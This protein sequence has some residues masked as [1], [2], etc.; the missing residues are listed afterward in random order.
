MQGYKQV[1]LG[2]KKTI[3]NC[4]MTRVVLWACKITFVIIR[5]SENTTDHAFKRFVTLS[6]TV[7]TYDGQHNYENRFDILKGH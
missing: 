4:K 5:K 6:F 7:H 3:N 2:K 1:T